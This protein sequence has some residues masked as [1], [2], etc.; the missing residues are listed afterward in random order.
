MYAQQ[1]Q[2]PQGGSERP[3]G[4]PPAQPQGQP[5]TQPYGTLPP[6][7]GQRP[8]QPPT[9]Q[10]HRQ[11]TG[12]GR[13]VGMLLLGLVIGFVGG[14]F[15]ALAPGADDP[16]SGIVPAPTVTVPV[17]VQGKPAPTVTVTQRAT[18]TAKPAGPSGEF[19]DGTWIV[20]TDIKPGTYRTANA[21]GLCYWAR[22]SGMT[23]DLDDVLANGNPD[24]STTITI[25][26]TD[27]AFQSER[28]GTWQRVS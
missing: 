8:V 24:K 3:D 9:A 26:K 18:V 27:K 28:C 4:Q 17:Q 11:K 6:P 10:P 21:S 15:A 5:R 14:C 22:L 13:G 12:T 7:Y 2:P 16:A 20:G 25:R 19:G 1:P 23:G